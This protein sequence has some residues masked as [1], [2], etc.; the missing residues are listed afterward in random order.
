MNEKLK[1][2]MRLLIPLIFIV[3]PVLIF[4]PYYLEGQLPGPDDLVQSFANRKYLTESIEEGV[5]SQWNPY[6]SN[7]IPQSGVDALNISNLFFLIAPFHQAIYLFYIAF[8]FTGALFFYLFLKENGCSYA[9][10]TVFS[11]IFAIP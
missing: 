9:V 7:G 5:F 1:K 8:L 2:E 11:V 6:L 3:I 10:S 4:L